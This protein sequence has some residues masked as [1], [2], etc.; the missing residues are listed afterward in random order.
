[1]L[2]NNNPLPKTN[3]SKQ[4]TPNPNKQ[5]KINNYNLSII[6]N[7]STLPPFNRINKTPSRNHS[8]NLILYNSLLPA[9]QW[10]IRFLTLS[11]LKIQPQ[12]S[13]L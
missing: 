12:E 11:D 1:M 10:K 8:N 3:N 13:M 5:S 9:H 6:H 4:P 2:N 7:P